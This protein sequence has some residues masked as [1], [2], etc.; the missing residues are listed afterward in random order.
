MTTLD[1]IW[2]FSNYLSLVPGVLMPSQPQW[3]EGEF[4]QARL[5]KEQ[6][7]ACL[8]FWMSGRLYWKKNKL[9]IY[10]IVHLS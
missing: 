3:S 9:N 1:I 5:Q 6:H 2:Y 7:F 10:G 4:V 8:S